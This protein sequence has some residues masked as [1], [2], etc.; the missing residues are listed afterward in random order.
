MYK[1]KGKVLIHRITT[2]QE[3]I[4]LLCLNLLKSKVKVFMH[5]GCIC[6]T[7]FISD[8]CVSYVH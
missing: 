5:H 1:S 2:M 7:A 4:V 8:L 6:C 3:K